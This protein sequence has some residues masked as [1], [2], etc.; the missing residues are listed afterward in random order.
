[1]LWPKE[2]TSFFS[3]ALR[4]CKAVKLPW[5][6]DFSG[7]S[8]LTE[9]HKQIKGLGMLRRLK[10]DVLPE[11]PAKQ[12]TVIAVDIPMGEYTQA[13]D[14]FV[15]WMEKQNPEKASSAAAAEKLAQLG[16]LKRIAAREKLS[17]VFN[18]I[19]NY[20]ES[21]EDKLAIYGIHK[22]IM[23]HGVYERYK[24]IGLII[25]GDVPQQN[26]PAIV[27]KFQ[28]DKKYRLFFGNL[29][30]AGTGITIAAAPV[31]L[32]IELDWVPGNHSQVEDRIHRI[33]QTRHTEMVYIV[34]RNTIEERLC[35]IIQAKQAIISAVLDGTSRK[36]DDMDIFTQLTRS[37][38]EESL[39]SKRKLST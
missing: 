15:S 27:R 6:W 32:T 29:I 3:F 21:T 4:Y 20:L 16:Y 23:R 12:R 5:G 2:Y 18:W 1:M 22:D 34:A 11:L 37:I 39:K 10:I 36:R 19:D 35:K 38:R 28:T 24:K 9:L 30:A 8:R 17:E 25:D 13:R 31:L 7:A 14:N 26:R 33:G